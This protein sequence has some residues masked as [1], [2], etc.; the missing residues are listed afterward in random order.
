MGQHINTRLL[1]TEQ[2][3]HDYGLAPAQLAEL[4]LPSQTSAGLPAPG[5]KLGQPRVTALLGALCLFTA[6]RPR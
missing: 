4:V 1:E 2:T 3:A 6:R 5:L